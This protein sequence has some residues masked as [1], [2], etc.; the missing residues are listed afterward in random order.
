MVFYLLMSVSMHNS[1]VHVFEFQLIL[2]ELLY[3]NKQDK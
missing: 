3:D 1:N 2:I